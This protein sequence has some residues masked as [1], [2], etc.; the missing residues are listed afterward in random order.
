MLDSQPC[1][2]AAESAL[3]LLV[4]GQLRSVD[5]ASP[6]GA[7]VVWFALPDTPFGVVSRA[8]KRNACHLLFELVELG[9]AGFFIEWDE[10]RSSA[11]IYFVATTR[12]DACAGGLSP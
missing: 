6:Q 11:K 9:E 12:M 5:Y 7:R 10:T 1:D 2:E 4:I 8:I 3:R